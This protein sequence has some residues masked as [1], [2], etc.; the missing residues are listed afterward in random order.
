M[1]QACKNFGEVEP[2]SIGDG[3]RRRY[4][5][6]RTKAADNR[7]AFKEKEYSVGIDA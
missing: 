3:L 2:H 6:R 5:M 7:N 4:Y 1:G